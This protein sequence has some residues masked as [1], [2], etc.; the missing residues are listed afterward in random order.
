[1]RLKTILALILIPL[2]SA[3]ADVRSCMSKVFGKTLG[4]VTKPVKWLANQ[5]KN[6]W[7]E[8]WT[9][10]GGPIARI[11]FKPL[12]EA[13]KKTLLDTFF[14]VAPRGPIYFPL[15]GIS[16]AAITRHIRD[17]RNIL[18]NYSRFITQNAIP[19]VR[20][21]PT[22]RFGIVG[23][24]TERSGLKTYLV[25]RFGVQW[26]I[27]PR[28]IA[29]PRDF[30][31]I[32][33]FGRGV[34]KMLLLDRLGV[35]FSVP[36]WI[37]M[38]VGLDM[39]LDS[40]IEENKHKAQERSNARTEMNDFRFQHYDFAETPLIPAVVFNDEEFQTLL[41]QY[42]Q[43]KDLL[44]PENRD[45]VSAELIPDLEKQAQEFATLFQ[46]MYGITDAEITAFF[47][48]KDERTKIQKFEMTL[49][50]L[51]RKL[52]SLN[53]PM[54]MPRTTLEGKQIELAKSDPV[55]EM[56]YFFSDPA[57]APLFRDLGF[58]LNGIPLN[59]PDFVTHDSSPL[60]SKDQAV[61]RQAVTKIFRGIQFEQMI[62]SR[63]PGWSAKGFDPNTLPKQEREIHDIVF[64]SPVAKRARELVATQKLAP[65]RASFYL[66][67]FFWA[68]SRKREMGEL[69]VKEF[70]GEASNRREV[71]ISDYVDES[72]QAMEAE[73]ADLLN[74]R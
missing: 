19:A 3:N 23:N 65:D 55:A 52:Q 40:K 61:L 25:D 32:H 14:P 35:Q 68:Y 48:E 6:Y 8:V 66:Q 47:E 58:Y 64:A 42:Y 31:P 72:I 2:L 62:H 15:D 51:N 22:M 33:G 44:K 73:A 63:I 74:R 69:G 38:G 9:S 17:N 21:L 71:L 16:P 45:K 53:D 36:T 59:H 4:I 27:E 20:D 57:T 67:K 11:L 56:M 30:R 1:M 60:R 18:Q 24:S 49:Q 28:H 10:E 39:V 29:R 43:T 46:M 54:Y 5:Q 41:S 34:E 37:A 13:E 12:P 7:R 70:I 26:T 50:E